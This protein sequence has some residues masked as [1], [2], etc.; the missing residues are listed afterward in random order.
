MGA[1]ANQ[2]PAKAAGRA[3]GSVMKRL[4]SLAG[5]L[6]VSACSAFGIRGGTESPDY[7]VIDRVGEV[8]IRHY[9]P[10]LAAETVVDGP[11]AEARSAGFRRLAAYIFGENRSRSDIAMTAPVAQAEAPSREIAMTA[12]VA[13]RPAAPAGEIAM[14]A[15]V[16][17][18]AAEGDKW[19][20]R[21][22]MPAQYTMAT[23]PEPVD[24]AIRIVPVPA[25]TLAAYRFSG[26]RSPE[27]MQEQQAVLLR[28]LQGSPW[29]AAGQPVDWFYDPPW[30]IAF[31]RRNEIVV[32]V[33]RP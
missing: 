19:V 16:A 26:S 29:R 21:F 8:E 3:G 30:T 17:T 24:P 5:V 11:E 14:T 6:L 10:R 27:A 32:P 15:P 25:E 23:L 20:V 22:F 18:R 28:T 4:S 9:G 2:S 13:T 7:Q 33:E 1:R 12:P 31:L